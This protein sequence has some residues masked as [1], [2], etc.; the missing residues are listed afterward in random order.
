MSW[1]IESTIEKAIVDG[2]L[3]GAVMFA[4]D[5]SGTPPTPLSSPSIPLTS[6]GK[7]NYAKSLGQSSLD[8]S[9][10]AP[11][12]LDT[13]FTLASM[14]KLLTAIAALQL[15]D[16][17]LIRL[18]DDLAP[19]LPDLASKPILSGFTPSGA[20]ILTERTRFL[21]L[22]HL[23]THSSG[24]GY[25]FLSPTLSTYLFPPGSPPSPPPTTSVPSRFDY[26][27]LFEPGTSWAYGSSLDWVGQLI[28]TLTSLPLEDYLHS[29]ILAPL[30]LLPSS[31]TFFPERSHSCTAK[32]AQMTA[33]P[34]G[35]SPVVHSPLPPPQSDPTRQAFGGEGGYASL[36]A[37]LEILHSLL[38]DDGR[39]LS[40]ETAGEL[41]RPQLEEGAKRAL[42]ENVKNPEWIVGWVPDTGEYDW[43]LG[44]LLVD[45]DSHGHR[46]G[47][48]LFWAGVFNLN[49]VS[50][51]STV[52]C[53][54]SVHGGG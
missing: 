21:T 31:I 44:G 49:W 28:T 4:K 10:P 13:V 19:F 17:D 39:L 20:P 33:R 8:P 27:L 9:S 51:L 30:G 25:H 35:S 36:Q 42:L 53:L 2:V 38:V 34:S 26:P 48:F 14:T 7:L 52:R 41:F 24:C 1:T 15:V 47:G 3:P 5:K 11:M 50:F 16:R 29:H 18:D 43:S 46:R 45:G 22:R 6:P 23:L 54:L 37:Y 32:L 12:A 40:S